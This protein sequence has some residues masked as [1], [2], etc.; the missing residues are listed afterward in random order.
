M[1]TNP[2]DHLPTCSLEM[3][4]HRSALLKQVREFFD[5]R[6]FIEVQTPCLSADTVVEVHLDPLVVPTESLQLGGHD[7][8]AKL[9]LQTSPEFAMK[10]L[11]A[12]GAEAIYQLAPVFRSGERGDFHNPEF[13]MLEWYQVGD[14]A[15]RAVDL[16]DQLSQDVLQALPANRTT[17]RNLFQQQ[18]G[19]D[20]IDGPLDR[21]REMAV[22]AAPGLEDAFADDRDGILDVLFSLVIQPNLSVD[23]P[24][25]VTH[26]PLTQG[27]LAQQSKE[28][29]QTAE[30]FEWFASGIELGNGYGELLD[31][32]ILADRVASNNKA[33]VGSGKAALPPESRLL[34]AMRRGLPPCAG[35][36]VGLD[37]LL[38]VQQKAGRIEDVIPFPIERA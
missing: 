2:L 12:A 5:R 19:I 29:P 32:T 7:L 36:A 18:L 15:E 24:Q 3:L 25:I 21:L 17:Y 10:R 28:D 13:T 14:T 37:R 20:P 38:M 11:V 34:E 33:R 6:G 4:R 8:P 22:A 30:R 26:Y 23:R 16:L 27:A 35:V 31:P 1:A 9:F